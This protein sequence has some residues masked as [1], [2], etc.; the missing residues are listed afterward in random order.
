MNN[1]SSGTERR[2][3]YQRRRRASQSG[4]FIASSHSTQA[5]ESCWPKT[6]SAITIEARWLWEN[7]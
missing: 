2:R 3:K 1:L 4:D 5:A 6:T 7:I